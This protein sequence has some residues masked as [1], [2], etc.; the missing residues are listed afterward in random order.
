MTKVQVRTDDVSAP[1]GHFSQAIAVTNPGKLVF[2]S[3]MTARRTDGSVLGAGDIEAQTRQ[4]CENIKTAVEAAGGGMEDIVRV[5]VFVRN[6]EHFDVIHQVR[7][8]YFPSPAPASTLLE[9]SKMVDP[10]M[11]IEITAIAVVPEVSA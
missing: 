3:G 1:V 10:D 9:V 5:D 11:L 8:E 4:V 2:L 7:R 6:I